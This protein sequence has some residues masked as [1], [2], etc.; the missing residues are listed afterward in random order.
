[1]AETVALRK[2][3]AT[4]LLVLSDEIEALPERARDDDEGPWRDGEWVSN[5]SRFEWLVDLAGEGRLDRKQQTQYEALLHSLRECLPVA[6]RL[7]LPVPQ[8]VLDAAHASPRAS[9]RAN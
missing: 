9:G 4:S 3:I 7:D 6:A 8:K 5:M 1:M 2:N